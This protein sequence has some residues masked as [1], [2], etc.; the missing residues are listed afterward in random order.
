MEKFNTGHRAVRRLRRVLLLIMMGLLTACSSIQFNY[1]H[2]ETLLYWWLN[3]YVD[4]EANQTPSVKKDI[5]NLF[6]WHRQTQLKDYAQVL[7]AAQ[8]QLQGSVTQADLLLDY[9]EIKT[10]LQLLALKAAP[11]LTSLAR[12]MSPEQVAQLEKKFASNNDE[13]RKKNLR[14]DVRQR[15]KVRFEQ[16]MEQFELW[17]GGFSRE[18]EQALRNASDGRVLNNEIW[19]E[20]RLRRQQSILNLVR[21]A[22]REKLSQDATLIL[23][24]NVIKDSFEHLEQK[25]FFDAYTDGSLRMVQMVI[26]MAT[27]AQKKHAIERM[28]GWIDDVNVLAAESN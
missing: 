22:Q 18:Q 13:F 23:V 6:Q 21:T 4:L 16:A 3:A 12:S 25:A 17:F 5:S 15:Q 14:G 11:A 9:S 10:R 19:L 20:E 28:Q 7:T 1:N 2:G 8:R 24:N 27:P 26:Q